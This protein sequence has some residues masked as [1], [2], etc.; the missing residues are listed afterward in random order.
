MKMTNMAK[1]REPLKCLILM[2]MDIMAWIMGTEE[3]V[4]YVA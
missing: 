3:Q 2:V 1:V 4:T